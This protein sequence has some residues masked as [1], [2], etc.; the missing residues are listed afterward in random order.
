MPFSIDPRLNEDYIAVHRP[1][2]RILDRGFCAIPP[3]PVV[4]VV[5]GLGIDMQCRRFAIEDGNDGGQG[6]R[7]VRRNGNRHSVQRHSVR[8]TG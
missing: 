2:K 4:C 8:I 1:V 5:P 3:E 7:P 6:S